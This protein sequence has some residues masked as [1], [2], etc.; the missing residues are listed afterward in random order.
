M[1]DAINQAIKNHALTCPKSS[2]MPPIT[3]SSDGRYSYANPA[4]VL[5]PTDFTTKS[6][7]YTIPFELLHESVVYFKVGYFYVLNKF[8]L[9]LDGATLE[10]PIRGRDTWNFNTIR[11][12]IAPG[13]YN[14]TV[15]RTSKADVL[16]DNYCPMFS[17]R[18]SIDK[19]SNN[20][21]KT[22]S[23]WDAYFVCLFRYIA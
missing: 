16:P 21:G 8:D 17:V 22:G 3:L 9:R 12:V 1:A 19:N 2:T 10:V 14:L 5:S 7:Y 15:L 23:L 4:V 18:M 20:I 11:A 6:T 13:Q